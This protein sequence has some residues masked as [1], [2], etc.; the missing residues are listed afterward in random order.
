M[1]EASE[2]VALLLSREGEVRELISNGLGLSVSVGDRFAGLIHPDSAEKARH[3][4]EA[5][6]SG[7]AADWELTVN[8][9]GRLAPVGFSATWN[10]E[11][12]VV[13]GGRS[14]SDLLQLNEEMM[15]INNEQAN[16]LRSTFRQL[17]QRQPPPELYEELSK[18]NNE[19]ASAQRELAKKTATLER[20]NAQK[21]QLLGM[22]AHDLRNP[23]AIISGY[24]RLLERGVAGPVQPKQQD[25]LAR[26]EKS[27]AFMLRLVEDLLDFAAI[28]SGV[29]TLSRARV[30]LAQLLR[31]EV[32]V[33]QLAAAAKQITVALDAPQALE[34]DA[35]E[36]KLRQVVANLLSNAVKFSWEESHVRLTARTEGPEVRVTVADAGQG[37]PRAEQEKL[38]RPFGRTSVQGTRGEKSTGLGLAIVR[39]IVEA[40]RGRIW[41]ESETGKG[42]TF[43]FTLPVG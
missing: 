22:V 30:D 4:L 21:D 17:Q 6:L 18:L 25:L 38:F 31:E 2:S 10:G 42:A 24:T 43:S 35:D 8:L 1:P 28:E 15:R 9:S 23:L 7:V 33:A 19:L 11:H 27:T 20:T 39:R 3:F 5:A 14:R 16:L 12:L 26:I 41:V 34:V 37:I 29:V 13:V 36:A 32:E 40:H